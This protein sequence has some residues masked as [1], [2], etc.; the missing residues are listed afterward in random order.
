MARLDTS[1]WNLGLP[2]ALLG[3]CTRIQALPDEVVADDDG[4]STSDATTTGATTSPSDP[5]LPD[6]STSAATTFEPVTSEATG[7]DCSPEVCAQQGLCCI[8][9]ICM[10]L[11]SECPPS[12]TFYDCC[13]GTCSPYDCYYDED[14]G[15]GAECTDDVC[16]AIE[17]EPYC[18]PS[19]SLEFQIQI[20][21]A[22]DVRALAFIDA[23]GDEQRDVV[24]GEG[25]STRLLRGTDPMPIELEIGL[26]ASVIAVGDLDGDQDEDIVIGDR[27]VDG[28]LRVLLQDAPL[29]FSPLPLADLQSV[30]DIA[31]VDVEG[32][33]LLD[34]LVVDEGYGTLFLH[35]LGGAMFDVPMPLFDV[36]TSISAG[37]IDG[38]ELP[39][40]VLHQHFEWLLASNAMLGPM[41]LAGSDHGAG[42]R[43]VEVGDFDGDGDGDVIAL[44]A[45]AGTTMAVKWQDPTL[46]YAP[47]K[48]FW[49]GNT[50]V[51]VQADFDD[52]GRADIVSA[53]EEAQ[54]VVARGGEPLAPSDLVECVATFPTMFEV[55]QLAVGDITGDGRLDIVTSDGFDLAIHAQTP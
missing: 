9:Q 45:I 48:S 23:D 25:S 31:L 30:L 8:D 53:G 40:V 28:D 54:L 43:L 6:P 52:D 42:F 27:F 39:D 41:M 34:V 19:F 15:A 38:D 36:A 51:A 10:P 47:H 26:E 29:A 16:A 1:V 50:T 22:G 24:I 35:N 46:G 4:T 21:L 37:R 14:C 44:Q 49:I 18:M 2:L 33:G 17:L 55:R 12:C 32:D 13:A 20:P 11:E 7:S 5:S 3:G